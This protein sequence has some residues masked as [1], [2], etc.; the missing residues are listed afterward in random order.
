MGELLF[1]L[2][3]NSDSEEGYNVAWKFLQKLGESNHAASVALSEVVLGWV[4][5]S[6]VSKNQEDVLQAVDIL[7]DQLNKKPPGTTLR[8]Q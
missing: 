4:R 2:Q 3:V 7:I 6:A 5:E 1:L 8:V